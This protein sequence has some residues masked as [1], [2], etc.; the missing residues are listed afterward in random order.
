MLIRELKIKNFGKFVDKEIALKEGIN[1]VYGDNEAGKSTVH[2]FIQGMFFGITK[3]RGRVTKEDTYMRY[4]PWNNHSL[5]QGSMDIRLDQK[6]YRLYRNFHKDYKIFR[7]TDL[8][9]GREIPGSEESG[10]FH[11]P[12]LNESNYKN[13]ISISQKKAGTEKELVN[14]VQNYIA[15]LST[16]KDSEVNVGSALTF[17]Q[18]KKKLIEGKKTKEKVDELKQYLKSCEDE[19]EAATN[20][21]QRLFVLD[22]RIKVLDNMINEKL[23]LEEVISSVQLKIQDSNRLDYQRLEEDIKEYE[24]ILVKIEELKRIDESKRI[25]ELKKEEELKKIADLKKNQL[26]NANGNIK[27]MNLFFVLIPIIL[28]I[29]VSILKSMNPPWIYLL[30]I[31]GIFGILVFYYHKIHSSSTKTEVIYEEDNYKVNY[32]VDATENHNRYRLLESLQIRREK[33]LNY[34]RINEYE[35]LVRLIEIEK[36]KK[37]ESHKLKSDLQLLGSQLEDINNKAYQLSHLIVTESV[38][39]AE[40]KG[41]TFGEE[42]P[43]I[44]KLHYAN[45]CDRLE[46]EKLKWDLERLEE[47][48]DKVY[49]DQRILER[50]NDQ[51]QWEEQELKAISLASK[52]IEELSIQI[53]DSFGLSLSK[54]V[55]DVV[56]DITCG[57]YSEVKIDEKLN[58][59]VLY[60]DEFV[61][62]ESLS[63]G[64]IE[65]IYLALRLEIANLFYGGEE[66][67]LILDDCFA[68]YD[69][70]RLIETLE[71]LYKKRSQ[72]I[73][74]TCH[75]RESKMLDELN[76]P[77]HLIS[78]M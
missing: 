6:V 58:I 47:R 10:V 42:Q 72:V 35:E 14:E 15:N 69:D 51:V 68:Y 27:K 9:T 54:A 21:R 26:L 50:L 20:I 65:Q 5:Y 61:P 31:W 33:I 4:I 45:Q 52:T 64:T 36:Y 44:Q 60:Q 71:T 48:Q 57:R 59:K 73:I 41:E 16:S 53:H 40:N 29:V 7:I 30:G 74:F 67:P 63:V 32:E 28:S 70:K 12:N 56:S 78:M 66:L 3:T 11:I 18:N 34:Y 17:L 49:E 24:E 13:T 23:R 22:N 43:L 8:E 37:N 19:I 46:S 62:F 38:R 77:Y 76:I 2:T 55:S 39:N 25:D 75:K 1:I